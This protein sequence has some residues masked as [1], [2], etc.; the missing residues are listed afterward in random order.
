MKDLVVRQVV[1]SADESERFE[2]DLE[3]AWEASVVNSTF[4]FAR[5]IVPERWRGAGNCTCAHL[6]PQLIDL[7]GMNRRH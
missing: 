2:R 3:G 7:E 6:G 4:L 5:C 1:F